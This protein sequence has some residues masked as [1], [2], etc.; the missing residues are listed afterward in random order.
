MTTPLENPPARD[1]TPADRETDRREEG[2]TPLDRTG[3]R[4]R[5]AEEADDDA[6]AGSRRDDAATTGFTGRAAAG[7]SVGAQLG[8]LLKPVFADEPP[9]GDGIEATF[10]QAERRRRRRSRAVFAAA[11]V[12]VVLVFALGYVLTRVLLPG[13]SDRPAKARATMPAAAGVPPSDPMKAVFESVLGPSHLRMASREPGRGDGWRQYLV[14]TE[15]GRP[16]GLVEV[17]AYAAPGG[18]CF[19][20]LADKSACA[21]PERAPDGV[22][23]LRYIFDRDVDWQVNEVITRRLSDGRTIVVQ[24]TGERGTGTSA[25]RPPLSALLTAKTATD[26][27]LAAAFGALESCNGPA[28]GCPVLKVPVP[29]S[30]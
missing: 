7:H 21:R 18:L 16:H 4:D 30:P 3:A 11:V 1:R 8:E 26:P 27:R 12:V 24:A 20:V 22:E 25:G 15:S 13:A 28:A 29:V 5:A 10:R 19:P 17:S 2:G 14:L 9:L 6:A 23:Y